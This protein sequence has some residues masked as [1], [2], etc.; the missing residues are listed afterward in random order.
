MKKQEI[1]LYRKLLKAKAAEL[2]SANQNRSDLTAESSPDEVDKALTSMVSDLAG[3]TKS[4]DAK[5]LRRIEEALK[6]LDNGAFGICVECEEPI[7]ARRLE[8]V[9]WTRFCLSCKESLSGQISSSEE[10]DL[11]EVAEPE[12]SS[13][14]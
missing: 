6:R 14:R 5:L 8:A 1:E 2:M 7:S 3:H 12:H 11:E 9:P 4:K 13:F 10:P